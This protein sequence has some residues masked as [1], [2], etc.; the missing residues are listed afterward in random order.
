M[1]GSSVSAAISVFAAID[2]MTPPNSLSGRSQGEGIF[3]GADLD[4]HPRP[5]AQGFNFAAFHT[6]FLD[7]PSVY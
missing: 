6:H 3:V 2:E 5:G 1:T 4:V 7:E